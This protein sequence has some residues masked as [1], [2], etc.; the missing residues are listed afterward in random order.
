MQF[1]DCM[2]VLRSSGTREGRY[3]GHD[4][5]RAP[6]GWPRG[7]QEEDGQGQL[8]KPSCDRPSP[9]P[10]PRLSPVVSYWAIETLV[11]ARQVCHV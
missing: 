7:I 4:A 2:H 9:T 5:A 10:R 8:M 11:H 3:E 1:V 6:A